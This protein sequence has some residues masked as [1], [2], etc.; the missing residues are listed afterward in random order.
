MTALSSSLAAT[1]AGAWAQQDDA[2]LGWNDGFL[3]GLAAMDSTHREF[4]DCVAALQRAADADLPARLAD[5]ARH[6]VE[7]FAQE[8]QWM[9]STGFPAAQCHTD[10]HAAVLNSVREVQALLDGGAEGQVARDL[11]R[12]LADWFPGHADYM[13]AALSHWMS[14]R[15]HGGLPVVLRRRAP[16]A[17]DFPT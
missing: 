5:F 17:L 10:E 14:K 9:A 3:L 8:E 2:V 15:M 16:A 6:A 11:A 12:A 1:A 13:D 7:H 4:V